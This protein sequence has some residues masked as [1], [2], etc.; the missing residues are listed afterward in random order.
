[1][2]PVPY[3]Q[4]ENQADSCNHNMEVDDAEAGGVE[5]NDDMRNKRRRIHEHMNNRA[6]L[7]YPSGGWNNQLELPENVSDIF[8]IHS[9]FFSLSLLSRC[10]CTW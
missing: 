1:M 3:H 9:N 8:K 6:Q 5:I 4:A 7:I 2:M 10:F